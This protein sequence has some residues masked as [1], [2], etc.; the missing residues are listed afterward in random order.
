MVGLTNLFCFQL[1]I[2]DY[3]MSFTYSFDIALNLVYIF[4]LLCPAYIFS[5]RR[6]SGASTCFL[7]VYIS[8]Q[9]L[10]IQVVSRERFLRR[11]DVLLLFFLIVGKTI[12][13]D[14][15]KIVFFF[16]VAE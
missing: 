10:H 12:I 6:E 11:S 14:R 5:F 8:L 13:L 16:A 1:L 4:Q 2:N 3:P 9:I 7:T 15:L